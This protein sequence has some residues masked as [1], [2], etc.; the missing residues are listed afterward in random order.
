MI[1]DLSKMLFTLVTVATAS[2]VPQR[3]QIESTASCDFLLKPDVAVDPSSNLVS[4]FNFVIGHSLAIEVSPS[5]IT[6][7]NATFFEDADAGTFL[8]HDDLAVDGK[9]AEETAAI[10]EGFVG[11]TK[12]G[13]AAN[14]LFQSVT[15][16]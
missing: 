13:I 2:A 11:Q 6:N 9:T 12:E 7:G 10:L 1:F 8:V 5:S 14:W 16:A 3:R 15:C 4:E